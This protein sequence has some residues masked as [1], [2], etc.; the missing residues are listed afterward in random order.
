[1]APCL[2]FGMSH[3]LFASSEQN[4]DAHPLS[5]AGS[6]AQARAETTPPSVL[7]WWQMRRPD[8]TIGN[9]RSKSHFLHNEIEITRRQDAL[10]HH[11]RRPREGYTRVLSMSW[12]QVWNSV[13]MVGS[14]SWSPCKPIHVKVKHRWTISLEGI[15][16]H[17]GQQQPASRP[18]RLF[19]QRA[20]T[21]RRFN[22]RHVP[23]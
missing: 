13:S 17:Q 12:F 4:K 16:F 2:N 8:A 20:C 19:L 14:L 23:R 11:S 1:M 9:Q 22:G 7:A 18:V 5:P 10:R 6:E 21:T 15:F 3:L